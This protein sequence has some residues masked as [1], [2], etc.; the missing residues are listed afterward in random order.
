MIDRGS[1]CFGKWAASC[2]AKNSA[3]S[4]ATGVWGGVRSRGAKRLS[5]LA[6]VSSRVVP[7]L[8][9]FGL[10]RRPRGVLVVGRLKLMVFGRKLLLISHKGPTTITCSMVCALNYS[11]SCEVLQSFMW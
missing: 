4:S 1:F 9:A 8:G 6:V 5:A 3:W 11:S 2:K 10:G 7:R